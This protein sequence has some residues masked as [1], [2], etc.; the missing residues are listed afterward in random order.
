MAPKLYAMDVCLRELKDGAIDVSGSYPRL[1][2]YMD[3][4]FDRPSFRS[5]AE[6]GPETIVWGWTSH[7]NKE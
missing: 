4:L 6:Y 2:E 1:R 3:A 7:L 5:T